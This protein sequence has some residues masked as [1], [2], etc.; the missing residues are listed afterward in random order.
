MNGAAFYV[1][2]AMATGADRWERLTVAYGLD[3]ASADTDETL[4]PYTCLS[5]GAFQ[6]HVPHLPYRRPGSGAGLG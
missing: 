1:S 4:A 6:P 3:P 5:A 2:V